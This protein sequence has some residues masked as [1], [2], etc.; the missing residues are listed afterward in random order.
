MSEVLRYAGFGN[1]QTFGTPVPAQF[2]VDIQSASLDAPSGVETYYPGAIGRGLRTRRPGFY[3][4]SGNI[5]YGWDI[6][7]IAAMLR[8]TLGGYAF[9]EGASDEHNLHEIWGSAD[10]VLPSFTSRIGKDLFEHVFA[11]CV[12]N[13][14]DLDLATDFLL[15]TMDTVAQKDSKDSLAAL[16]ELLLP[17]EFP[18]AFHEVTASLGDESGDDI[19]AKVRAL[20]LS[21]S[22]GVKAESGRGIGSRY[23]RRLNGAGR[24][25]T[26][27]VELA[28][29]SLDH[30]EAFW[31]GA[32][33]PSDAGATD[34]IMRINA[35]AGEDGSLALLVPSAHFTKV[36]T[37]PKGRD[38]ITQNCELRAMTS[39]IDLEESGTAVQSELLASVLN[40]ADDLE[41]ESA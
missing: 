5:V 21:I 27:S 20:K 12:A 13:K 22:N 31:G 1:E 8:W 2:H 16:G 32:S 4:P 36:P 6:R 11:G 33:G 38:E 15:A 28:Y 25:V 26:I 14:L 34:Q 18:L 30:L 29:E 39:E 7:T 17:D 24:D 10:I 3:A 40:D 23:P 19:S 37:Q 9:T 35:D 41:G